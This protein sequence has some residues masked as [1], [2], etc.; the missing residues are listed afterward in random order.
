MR[1]VKRH[2][3][4]LLVLG[5]VG[6]LYGITATRY[7]QG[8]DNGE[9]AT[10]F[11]E[12]G[13]AH[14]SGYPLYT[15]WLR[16]FCWLPAVTP[17]HGA[18]LA[19][20]LLAW[21]ANG[22][23]YAAMLAW[24]AHPVPAALALT[25]YALAR[26]PWLLATSAEVFALNQLVAAA[27]VLLSGAESPL[28]GPS[29]ATAL[30]L[31]GGLVASTHWSGVLLAPCYAIGL[32]R[33]AKESSWR[34]TVLRLPLG[35]LGL[36]PFFYLPWVAHAPGDRWVWGNFGTV[37]G[38]V[39]HV[40]RR[41]YGT[42]TLSPSGHGLDPV[43]YLLDLGR[44]LTAEL[45]GAPLVVLVL[46]GYFVW[47]RQWQRLSAI[48][49]LLA[50]FVLAGPCFV[51][52]FNIPLSG[53]GPALVA[54]FHVLP[55][56]LLVV[57]LSV[58]LPPVTERL[59]AL[60]GGGALTVLLG[61]SMLINFD[62]VLQLNGPNVERYLVDSLESLPKGAVLFGKN[63]MRLFGL[64][65]LQ[66]A[67]AVRPDVVHIAPALLMRAWYRARISRA[68]SMA[69]RPPLDH[70]TYNGPGLVDDLQTEGRTVFVMDT[71]DTMLPII[72]SRPSYPLGTLV[73]LLRPGEIEPALDELLRM[74]DAWFQAHPPPAA[75]PLPE[76]RWER[77]ARWDY[78]RTLRYLAG[79][80]SKQ[81]QTAKAFE[82]RRFAQGIV[83]EALPDD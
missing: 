79:E 62:A 20:A 32:C 64:L 70:Q 30:A 19:T 56:M 74:N 16:G 1:R 23:L 29:R 15:L 14:P 50:A 54:R 31:L 59:A 34:A 41:E 25:L 47:R 26:E 44:R 13:I 38:M 83:G 68:L 76:A 2:W 36:L 80:L 37:A 24:G 22:L 11:A 35:L 5:L 21:C 63:D 78:V 69:I 9:F 55:A 4:A 46:L 17:A 39:D 66:R 81:G 7:V 27:A 72:L 58:L 10:L 60:V 71:D 53:P 33:A 82:L 18:A 73:R 40:L 42:F 65:Y 52:L 45:W 49:P 3:L 75:P 61:L 12:G 48:W 67:R 8:G 6:L 51:S 77:V 57:L 43:P 28:R